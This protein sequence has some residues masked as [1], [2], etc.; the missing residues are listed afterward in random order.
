MMK[1]LLIL[2]A[3]SDQVPLIIS[4]KEE[5]YYVVVCDN[6]TTNPG[7]T[8]VD[9]HYQVSYMDKKEVLVVA[10]GEHIDGII[11][12]SEPAMPVVAYISEELGLI[13]NKVCSIET[14]A[15]KSKF[16]CLQKQLNLYTPKHVIVSSP[17][18]AVAEISKMQLPVLVKACE[19]SATRGTFK[20]TEFDAE[21]IKSKYLESESFSWNKT[22]AIEEFIEM[23]SLTTYE[24]DVFINGDEFLWDGL[25]YT[26]RS[27]EAPMIPMTYSGPL[28]FHDK[29]IPKIKKVL[30]KIFIEAGIRHG[31]YN[32]ELYFAKNGEPFVIEVNTRQGGRSLPKFIKQYC[33]VDFTKLLVTTAV[34]ENK[35]FDQAKTLPR[36]YH[37]ISHHLLF[38]HT[39]GIYVGFKVA[40]ELKDKIIYSNES[41]AKGELVRKT[42]N[43]TDNLGCVDFEFTSKQERDRYAFD[44]E[45]FVKVLIS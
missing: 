40:S 26:Q 3:A 44:I 16:R 34:G 6:T 30:S 32:I 38:G 42:V 31:Q 22:V 17:D 35:F 36:N 43:G 8:M 14:L 28:D 37:Y 20:I 29:H 23:P 33:G 15:D 1:R 9:K 25:F 11:S 45:A 27:P 18:D 2:G 39:D 4:A 12:N 5:G 13:G 19:C 24:G 7:L 41:R 10:K 21:D